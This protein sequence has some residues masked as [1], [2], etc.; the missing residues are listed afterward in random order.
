MKQLKS[1]KEM[2]D[3]VEKGERF[4]LW[5]KK[6]A[7]SI[8]TDFTVIDSYNDF[9]FK[10]KEYSVIQSYPVREELQM[11]KWNDIAFGNWEIYLLNENETSNYMKMVMARK[12][13]DASGAGN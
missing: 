8:I 9:S 11:V 13:T 7:K 4:F 1:D 10:F 12:I 3:A 6:R 2:K 5:K